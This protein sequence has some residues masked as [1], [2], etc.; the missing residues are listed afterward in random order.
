MQRGRSGME[1]KHCACLRFPQLPVKDLWM[2]CMW[3]R[4]TYRYH[5]WY[6]GLPAHHIQAEVQ[7]FFLSPALDA[8][9]Q[10]RQTA[11]LTIFQIV[12]FCLKWVGSLYFFSK[13]TKSISTQGIYKGIHMGAAEKLDFL[14]DSVM[15]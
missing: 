2:A 11:V 1:E 9:Q 8:C 14:L 5:Q 7:H 6:T 15:I 12:L 13:Q 4:S 10:K 3:Q